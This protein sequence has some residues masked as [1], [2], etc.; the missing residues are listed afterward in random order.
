MAK[1]LTLIAYSPGRAPV[2]SDDRLMLLV[3]D[4]NPVTIDVSPDPSTWV[5]E[6]LTLFRGDRVV[7]TPPVVSGRRWVLTG[8]E[9]FG[10]FRAVASAGVTIVE[11]PETVVTAAAPGS[12]SGEQQPVGAVATTSPAVAGAVEVRAGEYDGRFAAWIALLFACLSAAVLVIISTHILADLDPSSAPSD[13]PGNVGPRS[14]LATAAVLVG[15]SSVLMLA[16]AALAALEV[17][18]RLRRRTET[19][20]ASRGTA[21]TLDKVPAIL[22]QSGRLRGPIALLTTGVVVLA[23]AV[24]IQLHW[25]DQYRE[26]P[27]PMPASTSATG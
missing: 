14:G 8:D 4:A 25:A 20:V 7:A 10:T 6:D 2:P 27:A 12:P 18:S 26:V 3:D 11:S 1:E 23:I 13:A 9:R 5:P 24:L 17:R 15:V 21:G 22:E 16:G 19:S